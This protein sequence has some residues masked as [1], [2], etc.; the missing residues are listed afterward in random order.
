ML[1]LCAASLLLVAVT[2][3]AA[4]AALRAARER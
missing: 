3:F 4:G 2:P 1:F